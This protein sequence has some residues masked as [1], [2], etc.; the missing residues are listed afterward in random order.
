MLY[1]IGRQFSILFFFYHSRVRLSAHLWEDETWPLKFQK[2]AQKKM[3]TSVRKMVQLDG[4]VLGYY[5]TR[6]TIAS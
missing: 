4:K 1:T 5:S 6:V 3:G 2:E